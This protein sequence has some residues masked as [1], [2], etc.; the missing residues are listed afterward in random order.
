MYEGDLQFVIITDKN[1]VLFCGHLIQFS[2]NI[3]ALSPGRV[4]RLD[5]LWLRSRLT[6]LPVMD[7]LSEA[8]WKKNKPDDWVGKIEFMPRV[9][10]IVF[11]FSGI[12]DIF[13][14]D[15]LLETFFMNIKPGFYL[16]YEPAPA[17]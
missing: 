9:P 16:I 14:C 11:F 1:S 6:T 8:A 5:S 13:V 2:N 4:L 10:S 17:G 12:Q 7:L 15:P 3:V